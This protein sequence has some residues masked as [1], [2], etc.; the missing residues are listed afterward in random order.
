MAQQW[1]GTFELSGNCVLD[2]PLDLSTPADRIQIGS[3]N[4]DSIVASIAKSSGTGSGQ[5][6]E[7]WHDERTLTT[8]STDSLDLAGGL[9][10]GLGVT[11]TFTKIK[12]AIIAI[13]APDG[14]KKLRVGPNNTA[15]AW[16]G[17]F[18][19]VG[20]NVYEEVLDWV[21]HLDFRT[22]WTVTAGTGDL[23]IINNP[24]AGSVTYRILLVGTK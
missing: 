18:G 21:V 1:G 12:L 2:N 24:S 22:G 5:A 6:N 16:Q 7:M 9:T 10:N 20:A 23:L 15:N 4:F 11:V 3:G 17:W 19:G 13:D 8:T 14:T